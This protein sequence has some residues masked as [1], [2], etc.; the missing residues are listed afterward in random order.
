MR[1]VRLMLPKD[2]LWP[3]A[4]A[5]AIGRTTLIS[6]H[7]ER[8]ATIVSSASGSDRRSFHRADSSPAAAL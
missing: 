3:V 2:G 5:D 1:E 6:A 4:G 8:T 7:D